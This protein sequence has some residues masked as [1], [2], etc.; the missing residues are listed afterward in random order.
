MTMRNKG[1]YEGTVRCRAHVAL[2]G[3]GTGLSG[4]L[5]VRPYTTRDDRGFSRDVEIVDNGKGAKPD[6][7]GWHR[8]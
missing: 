3:S 7:P 1:F 8:S 2:T 5:S 4:A 6:R